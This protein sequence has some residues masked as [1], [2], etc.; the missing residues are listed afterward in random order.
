MP[1]IVNYALEV[2]DHLYDKS[3]YGYS[4][5]YNKKKVIEAFEFYILNFERTPHP[6]P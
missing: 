2:N 4:S 1:N 3:Y 6:P 5:W